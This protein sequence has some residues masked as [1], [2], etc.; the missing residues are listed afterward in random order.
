[1]IVQVVRV[2]YKDSLFDSV[3]FLWINISIFF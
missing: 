2:R 1:M 3:T